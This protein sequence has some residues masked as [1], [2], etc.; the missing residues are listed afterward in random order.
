[1]ERIEERPSDTESLGPRELARLLDVGRSLV[2]E[3][4]LDAVL[5]HILE[6]ARDLTGAQYAAL[7]VLDANKRELE[8]FLFVG[9]DEQTR[10]EIGPLPR[11]QGILG[12]LIR[13]PVPLRLERISDHPRSYG[14]PSGHPDMTTFAGVPVTVRGEIYGNLYLTEKAGG[15]PFDEGDERLLIV[16]SEWA[17]IAIE[18]ARIYEAAERGREELARA[19]RGLQATASLSRE[20]SG[21]T[22]MGR[23]V[24]LIVKRGRALVD[25]RTLVMLTPDGEDYAVAGAAGEGIDAFGDSYSASRSPMDDAVRAD[26]ALRLEG[27]E[28]SWFERAGIGATVALVVPMRHGRMSEGVL[29]A[30]DRIDER[31]F[32]RDDELVLSSFAAAAATAIAAGRALESDRLKR[33]IDASEQERRRWARELHDETMQELGALRVMQ[34]SALAT[35]DP[36]LLR[37]ALTNASE[38]VGRVIE[39][40]E[41]L[42]TELRPAALDQLGVQAAI[43]ALV[44]QLA[45]RGDL[46]I[47]SDFDLAYENG[48]SET[49]HDPELESAVYRIVQE[50]LNN[51]VKHADASRAKIAVVEDDSRIR[52]TVEDD[53]KGVSQTDGDRQGFGLIGMRERAERLGGELTIGEAPGGGVRVSVSLPGKL[54]GD[55]ETG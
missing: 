4:E 39:S 18:N 35:D 49:R 48:R 1:L 36:E 25:A 42:I 24:E 17:A 3:L 2:S 47:E 30:L 9:I 13:H 15:A 10:A 50:A 33:S 53:G 37:R 28:L 14:F 34:E 41:A 45:T 8:R 40:L 31:P 12:E 16:L 29:V 44:D 52:L 6:A 38:Q 46:E 22:D 23:V 5:E 21:E 27:D 7:G 19:A 54:R 55:G 32:S 51:V 11:G 20:L 43:E 26:S